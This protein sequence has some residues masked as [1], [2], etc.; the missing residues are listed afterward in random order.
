MVH[1]VVFLFGS[2]AVN[3][4]VTLEF[5]SVSLLVV[6]A[7]LI[8]ATIWF[9]QSARPEPEAL[10]PLEIMSQSEFRNADE[11]ARKKMLNTVRA[12][13]VMPPS[14]PPTPPINS[15]TK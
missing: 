9:W 10:A 15:E 12:I 8:W 3:L 1:D 13:P 14:Q 11:E 4:G 2:I 6:A 5:V 7:G